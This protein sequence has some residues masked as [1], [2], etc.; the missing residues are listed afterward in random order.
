MPD[1]PAP[2]SILD[3]APVSAGSSPAAALRNTLDLARH[4]EDLGTLRCSGRWPATISSPSR[5]T[6]TTVICGLPSRFKVF[7]RVSQHVP[8]LGVHG[9]RRPALN[10]P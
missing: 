2:L 9:W 5:P 8:E 4:A 7:C 3:L 1:Q 6:H 10:V